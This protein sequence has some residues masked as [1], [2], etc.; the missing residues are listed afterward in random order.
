[1]PGLFAVQGMSFTRMS[2]RRESDFGVSSVNYDLEE[3]LKQR[4]D[5]EEEFLQG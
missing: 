1:M 5:P 3:L 2:F 4:F